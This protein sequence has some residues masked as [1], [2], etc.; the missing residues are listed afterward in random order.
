MNAPVT[1]TVPAARAEQLAA[2]V[3]ERDLDALVVTD[4]VDIRWL[5]GFTGSNAVVVVGPARTDGPLLRFLTDFRYVT[6]AAEQV[7][8]P[9]QRIDGGRDLGG[10]GL[11]AHL[12]E[13]ARRVG[14]DAGH[15]T[16]AAHDRLRGA[17]PEGVEL[18][19]AALIGDLRA[20]KDEG[21]VARIRAAAELADAA[22]REVV[23][24]GPVVGRTEAAVALDL[25]IA[26]RRLGASGNSFDPIVA[27]GAHGALP[28]ASPRDVEIP[29]GVLLTVDWGAILDGYCSDCTRTVAT[30]PVSDRAR[31][32]YALVLDAQQRSLAAVRA[33]AG[34]RDVDAVAREIIA[35]AGHGEHFG[36]GLGHGVGLEIHEPPTLSPRGAGALRAGEIVTV[37]PGVYLPGELGV[38][39]EDLAVVTAD[40]SE[41][42]NTLPKDLVT[43]G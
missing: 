22:F 9:W 3:A 38:R 14:F 35:A 7:P 17:L 31:D 6:Q 32:V 18:R 21:E 36:H 25:E 41:V 28:H 33:G 39:I 15:L 8:D 13:G 10:A 16:V 23:L 24:E 19:P 2:A 12:P 37:E 43:V 1:E 29:A 27:A 11:V 20:V 42:L 40:G 5:T 30:G 34:A 4:L 26:M